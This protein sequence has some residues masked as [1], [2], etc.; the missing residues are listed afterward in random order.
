MLPT[1]IGLIFGFLPVV[2]IIII[3]AVLYYG[4]DPQDGV[5][6]DTES[7]KCK[8]LKRKIPYIGEDIR[9]M[10]SYMNIVLPLMIVY[11]L[12]QLYLTVILA[13]FVDFIILMSVVS[14]QILAAVLIRAIDKI[15]YV[16][17]VIAIIVT[18]LGYLYITFALSFLWLINLVIGVW[19]IGYHIRYF[20]IR[21]Y[22]FLKTAKELQKECD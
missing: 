4:V 5:R 10:V 2:V 13:D 12:Y 19:Y 14:I 3:L 20:H 21:R 9:Y 7:I 11:M 15:G 8:A 16:F 1:I 22:V 17:N 18:G 6:Y